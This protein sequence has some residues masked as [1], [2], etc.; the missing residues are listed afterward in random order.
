MAFSSKIRKF[1]IMWF[2]VKLWFRKLTFSDS[3][4]AHSTH[5]WS[6]QNL[7]SEQYLMQIACLTLVSI[8]YL[9]PLGP[10]APSTPALSY[11][12][13]C[14][15]RREQPQNS[16][17]DLRLRCRRSNWMRGRRRRRLTKTYVVTFYIC[18]GIC[19]RI[20]DVNLVWAKANTAEI[21]SLL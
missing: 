2:I 5:H 13:P 16:P 7:W 19:S 1:V 14:R 8:T 3:F 15:A 20:D 21:S 12:S 6:E 9:D 4:Y 17:Y 10:L 18:E 11:N